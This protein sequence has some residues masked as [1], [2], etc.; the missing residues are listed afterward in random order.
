MKRTGERWVS[1]SEIASW[2]WCPES[3]R[4]NT[5][6]A[7]PS[8]R[9]DMARGEVRHSLLAFFESW[10][11]SVVRLGWLLLVWGLLIALVAFV[12]VVFR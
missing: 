3:W 10:S 4:L 1:A 12:L 8:N 6:G 2:A 5:L 7:E 9:A 11:R